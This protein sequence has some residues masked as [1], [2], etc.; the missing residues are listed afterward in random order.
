LGGV[1]VVDELDMNDPRTYIRLT[2]LL[3]K[4]IAE[5]VLQPGNPTPSIASLV[6]DHRCARATCSKALRL[7]VDGGLLYR[8]PGLGYYVTKDAPDRLES[9]PA[10]TQ[11]SVGKP[12]RG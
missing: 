11:P 3:R 5:G 6:R 2:V 4:Q 8:V 12:F 7:L 10:V 1:V 9:E